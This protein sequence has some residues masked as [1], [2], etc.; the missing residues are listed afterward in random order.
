MEVTL[1]YQATLCQIPH[2]TDWTFWWSHKL[3][4]HFLYTCCFLSE[5]T[6]HYIY[7]KQ[8]N[9]QMFT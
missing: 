4:A 3:G 9:L 5:K 6:E 2:L 1:I 8:T 7:I